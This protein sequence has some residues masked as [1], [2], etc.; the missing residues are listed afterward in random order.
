MLTEILI[1]FSDSQAPPCGTIAAHASI[2]E[3]L[4][5]VWIGKFGSRISET[6]KKIILDEIVCHEVYT[7][8]S[9]RFQGT[10]TIY[11]AR[12]LDVKYTSPGNAEYPSYYT[13][14][15]VGAW[16]KVNSLIRL[17]VSILG[18]LMGKASRLPI[19]VTMDQSQAAMLLVLRDE[20]VDVRGMSEKGLQ[21]LQQMI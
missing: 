3:T 17:N 10:H 8:F 13:G 7:Y 16:F 6:S 11:A 15:R 14:K 9:K 12:T 18:V 5:Y 19:R 1:K 21:T 20:K 4:G 2:I